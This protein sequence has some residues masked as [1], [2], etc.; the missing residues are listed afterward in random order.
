MVVRYEMIEAAMK[1]GINVHPQKQMKNLGLEYDK[2][3]ACPIADCW[4]FRLKNEVKES[5]LPS[6]INRVCDEYFD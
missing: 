3:E 4:F 2:A 5:E 6:Y 1:Y